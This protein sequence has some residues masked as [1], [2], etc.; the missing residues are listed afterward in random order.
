MRN[1]T[2]IHV[3]GVDE[4]T[5]D[6]LSNRFPQGEYWEGEDTYG[7]RLKVPEMKLQLNWFKED[8]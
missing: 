8:R 6:D 4:V 1:Y 3:H 7:Y 5:F 2:T